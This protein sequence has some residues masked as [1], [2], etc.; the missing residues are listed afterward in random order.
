MKPAAANAAERVSQES[1]C[2]RR[3]EEAEAMRSA[4]C[5]VRNE[6]AAD[7]CHSF[8]A[9]F[10]LTPALSPGEREPPAWPNS[11]HKPA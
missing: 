1:L 7:A 6:A 11:L 2:S 5:G 9:S 3:R 4:E 10:P 8:G